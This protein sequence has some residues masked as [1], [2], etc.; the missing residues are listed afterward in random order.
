MSPLAEDGRRLLLVDLLGFGRSPWPMSSTYS[1]EEHL[2]WLRRT[3][4]SRGAE[5]N[6]TIVAHSFGTLIAAHYAAIYAGEIKRVYLLGA[7][8]FDS[9]EEA[10]ERIRAMSSIAALFSLNRFAAREGCM[11]LCAFRP[12]LTRMAPLLRPDLPAEV[13]Q[14]GLL[15]HW[16]SIRGAIEILQTTPLAAALKGP[17]GS[18]TVFVHGMEDRVTPMERIHAVAKAIGAAVI[19]VPGAHH[20]YVREMPALL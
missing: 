14:D 16:P 8:V 10:R 17:I 20:D 9:R 3:L 7:P 15:H 1:L 4:V 19:E 5:R 2:H 13:A 6:L 18:K 11:T 12:L